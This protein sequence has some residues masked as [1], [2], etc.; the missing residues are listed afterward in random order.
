MFIEGRRGLRGRRKEKEKSNNG[1][2]QYTKDC[3]GEPNIT[4]TNTDN[5]TKRKNT[6]YKRLWRWTKHYNYKYWQQHQTEK[7]NIQKTVKVNQTLQLQIL[8]TTV[9]I[10]AS[11]C[12]KVQVTDLNIC[13]LSISGTT[14]E[15]IDAI[16]AN[17]DCKLNT[18]DVSKM[19]FIQ[20]MWQT[21][22]MIIIWLM[23]MCLTL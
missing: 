15:N 17:V 8:T 1:K 23:S 21:I 2:R 3:E 5:N 13:N 14:A 12:R 7:H 11:N 6:I 10:G 22:K 18:T 9:I 4:T 16:L 19:I 20:T